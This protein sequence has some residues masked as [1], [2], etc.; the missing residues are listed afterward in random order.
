MHPNLR[1]SS[2]SDA[3]VLLYCLCWHLSGCIIKPV[4]SMGQSHQSLSNGQI[5]N[6]LYANCLLLNML[7]QSVVIMTLVR[8]S[9]LFQPG[10][11]RDRKQREGET[12]QEHS[13]SLIQMTALK[14]R[15]FF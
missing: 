8:Q 6:V 11:E 4:V 15:A 12:L 2:H 14:Q 3:L 9:V 13:G 1:C 7:H 5:H 10:R